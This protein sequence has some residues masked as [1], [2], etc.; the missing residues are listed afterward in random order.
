ME[1]QERM[2][3]RVRNSY[4]EVVAFLR[5][6]VKGVPY[7]DRKQ[8]QLFNS[9]VYN[10]L[11]A[12]LAADESS[13]IV[14]DIYRRQRPWRANWPAGQYGRPPPPGR[15]RTPLAVT[16]R[17]RPQGRARF[18]GH[19]GERARLQGHQGGWSASRCPGRRRPYAAKASRSA[20]GQIWQL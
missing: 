6:N 16:R 15:P 9:H 19:Q 2:G 5:K 1:I 12:S 13:A 10:Q 11:S 14:N 17:A 7:P 20:L 3:L 8:L 4:E 18:Q